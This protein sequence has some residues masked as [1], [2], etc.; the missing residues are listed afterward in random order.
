MHGLIHVLKSDDKIQLYRD[1]YILAYFNKTN[2][3][4]EDFLSS[5]HLESKTLCT[6]EQIKTII[7]PYF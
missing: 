5:F 6:Y 7:E 2:N 3:L 4:F 1:I